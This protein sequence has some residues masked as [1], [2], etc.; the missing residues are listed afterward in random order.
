MVTHSDSDFQGH[1]TRNN[2]YCAETRLLG[3][4]LCVNIID[5]WRHVGEPLA[6]LL[7]SDAEA[8]PHDRT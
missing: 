5:A 7:H 2:T 4:R 8:T 1:I 3:P 6:R